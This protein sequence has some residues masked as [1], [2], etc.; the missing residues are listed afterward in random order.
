MANDVVLGHEHS[1][2]APLRPVFRYV[3]EEDMLLRIYVRIHGR[4]LRL[5]HLAEY[6]WARHHEG[7]DGVRR[8]RANHNG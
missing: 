4:M 7:R 2:P 8:R 6:A 1:L 5:F 3:R